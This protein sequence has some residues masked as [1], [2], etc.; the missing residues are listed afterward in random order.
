M[1]RSA[2]GTRLAQLVVFGILAAIA[3]VPVCAFYPGIMNADSLGQYAGAVLGGPAMDWHSAFL[4]YLWRGLIRVGSGIA[5]FTTLQSAIFVFSFYWLLTLC[6]LSIPAR[7]VLVVLVLLAPPTTPW[8][9]TIEKTTFMSAVLCACFVCSLRLEVGALHRRL[10]LGSILAGSAIGTWCRPNAVIIF[11]PIVGYTAW[12][13]R[14]SGSSRAVAASLIAAF[15]LLGLGAPA[16]AVHFGAVVRTYPQQATM[17]LDLLNLSI[18]TGQQ[19]I[20]SDI[21]PAP[22]ENLKAAMAPDPFLLG[23][24]DTSLRRITD[25][26]D[27]QQ[28]QSAWISAILHH[29][30]TYLHYRFDLYREYQ[31]LDLSTICLGSWH[32]YTGG[33]DTNPFGLASRKLGV[34][35]GFYKSLAGSV[36]FHPFFYVF[37]VLAVL[38]GAVAVRNRVVGVYGAV[39]LLFDL[40]N[41]LLIPGVTARMVVP[42]GLMLPFLLAGLYVDAPRRGER[43]A[44]ATMLS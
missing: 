6:R 29:P 5:L 4:I 12:Q 25:G 10:L 22:L 35:F 21:L 3:A 39:L 19:L 40:S 43:A 37:A 38:V 16:L 34:A 31:C 33:I 15:L 23:P 20:P 28:L 13:A 42:L 32:W 11:L 1:T 44:P 30:L 26:P 27:M 36:V 9:A 18:R 14:R 24:L 2:F 17:D 8:I 41:A 7:L